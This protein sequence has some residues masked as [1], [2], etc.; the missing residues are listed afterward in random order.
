VSATVD[1]NTDNFAVTYVAGAWSIGQAGSTTTVVCP[2]S[3]TYNGS[4]Q[5]PCTASWSS[6]GTDAEGAALTPSY[7]N[8][9]NFGTANA[10]A[11]YA[12]D[13]NHTGSNNNKNFSINKASVTATAGGGSNVYDGSSHSPS[14]CAVT[15]AYTGGLSC[16]NSPSS[17]GPGVSVTTISPVTS[18]VDLINF[19]VTPVNGSYTISKASTLIT[20]N[21]PNSNQDFACGLLG[22]YTATLKDTSNNVFLQGVS[23]TLTIGTQSTTGTTN[24]LGVA[25]FTIVLNQTPASVTETVALTGAWTDANRNT[26]G[27]QSA[28]FTIMPDTNVGPGTNAT[29]LYTGPAFSWTTS[30]TSST[31]TLTLNATIKDTG[32]CAGDITK[33]KV[34]F[35]VSSNDGASFNPVSNAQNLPVG[36]VNPG[37]TSV[38]TASTTSQY[39]IGSNL[40]ITLVVRVVVGGEYALPGGNNSDYDVPIVIAVPGQ[41]NTLTAGGKL[42]NSETSLATVAGQTYYANGYLGNGN[43]TTSGGLAGGDV[44]FGGFVQCNNSKCTNPQGKINAKIDTYNKP[45]GS[46]DTTIHHYFMKTNAIS[47]WGTTTSGSGFFSAK[48]NLSETTGGVSNGLDGGGMMQMIFA[49]PGA[50]YTYTSTQGAKSV[51]LTCPSG[52]PTG[53]ASIIIY[54]SN[55]LGGGVWFSSAWGPVVAGDLP[56]TIMKTMLSGTIAFTGGPASKNI[57]TIMGTPTTPTP[58]TTAPATTVAATN[59]SPPVTDNSLVSTLRGMF[60]GTSNSTTANASVPSV[61]KSSAAR[62]DE[63]RSFSGRAQLDNDGSDTSKFFSADGLLGRNWVSSLFDS[64]AQYVSSSTDAEGTVSITVR[65][66]NK[67]DGSL[68]KRCVAGKPSTHHVYVIETNAL[69]GAALLSGATAFASKT[70]VYEVMSNGTKVA[71]DNEGSMQI[72]FIA[73][74]QMIPLD[75][76]AA[77][78]TTCMDDSGC[79]AIA[80]QQSAGGLW[81]SGAWGLSSNNHAEAAAKTR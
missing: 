13:A 4:A 23:L 55:G 5:T 46:V 17:A 18:G 10:A 62:S 22:T 52:S 64:S 33:A 69:T 32:A 51:T 7:T 81:Y 30:P 66:C 20:F 34:S 58:K 53:C 60:V 14:A 2:A 12:G 75:A 16:T 63:R 15:G 74:S 77:G 39:N 67:P 38:G 56:Q 42:G 27:T 54:R 71:L 68:D 48:T 79:V 73:K 70:N 19:T 57:L 72:V 25:T 31:T 35:F 26:P 11:T 65:S 6:T 76:G 45:D 80:A 44:S 50:S 59:A 40:A 1:Q 8:N 47:G 9:T 29:S 49:N 3:V 43:G 78:G 21:G 36:L 61:V 37:D 41:P 24:A 28:S